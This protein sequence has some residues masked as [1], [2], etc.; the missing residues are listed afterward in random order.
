MPGPSPSDGRTSRRRFL[1]GAAA[2]VAL[3]GAAGWFR[4]LHGTGAPAAPGPGVAPP[5]TLAPVVAFLGTLFGRE[6]SAVDRTELSDRVAFAT[7]ATPGLGTDYD[8]LARH[9]DRF[10]EEAGA[11]GFLAASP[12]QR[13]A[14]VERIM[15]IGPPSVFERVWA[16][17][18]HSRKRYYHM[19]FETVPQLAWLYRHSG[20]PWRARGYARWPGIPGEWREYTRT[21]APYP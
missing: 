13:E 14:V 11:A 19:R 15:S 7:A 9:L 18:V 3:A 12:A 6:L 5:A 4:R 20:V 8:F 2:L 10:G 1:Y 21:G 17:L 16:H